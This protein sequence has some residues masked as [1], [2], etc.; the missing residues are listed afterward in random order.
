MVA[1][2]IHYAYSGYCHCEQVGTLVDNGSHEQAAVAA[3]FDGEKFG[4]CPV[5]A[6]HV[7]GGGDKVVEYV[8]F[9]HFCACFVPSLAVFAAASQVCRGVYAAVLEPQQAV[10]VETW[11]ERH[12]EASVAVEIDRIVAVLFEVGTA[13]NEHRHAGAVG[14]GVEH[15]L[16]DVAVGVEPFDFRFVKQCRG[17]IGQV[18]AVHTRGIEEGGEAVE[19]VVAAAVAAESRCSVGGELY[20][21]QALSLEVV[22]VGVVRGVAVHYGYKPV[23]S[24]KIH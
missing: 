14:R 24:G 18:V 1:H 17:V 8:L 22:D 16:G 2:H 5:V 20:F 21:A 3:A 12:V 7:F 15:L 9:L 6:Y 10:G 23:G 19:H 11:V 4:A 13:D